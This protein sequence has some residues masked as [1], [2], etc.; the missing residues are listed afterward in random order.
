MNEDADSQH[1]QAFA[2]HNDPPG[3]DGE[4]ARYERSKRLCHSLRLNDAELVEALRKMWDD[5]DPNGR[6]SNHPEFVRRFVPSTFEG[7][8][9]PAKNAAV[10]LHRCVIKLITG[11]KVTII[12]NNAKITMIV[13]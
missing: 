8:L 1:L 6:L 4:L 9:V 5:P 7:T 12:P 11:G 3:A 2:S 10:V 13:G